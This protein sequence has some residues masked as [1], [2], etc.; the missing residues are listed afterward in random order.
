MTTCTFWAGPMMFGLDVLEV[1]EI[2]PT[3]TVTPVPLA[4]PAVAGVMNLR[5]QIVTVVDLRRRLDLP[6]LERAGRSLSIVLR[7]PLDPVCL[8]VDRVG[9]IVELEADAVQPPPETLDGPVR[10]VLAGVCDHHTERLLLMLD[11][12]KVLALR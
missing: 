8:R 7:G 5:G 4:P 3:Q 10:E 11:S 6:P 2:V 1:Q 12:S 9:D